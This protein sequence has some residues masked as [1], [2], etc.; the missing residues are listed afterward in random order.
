[1]LWSDHG[2]FLAVDDKYD[3]TCP[4]VDDDTCVAEEDESG[5]DLTFLGIFLCT[6]GSIAL[7][8]GRWHC[9]MHALA[10]VCKIAHIPLTKRY[11]L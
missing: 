8:C 1:M 6:L 3:D 5:I 11:A 10:S 7:N 9:C 4:G 2:R